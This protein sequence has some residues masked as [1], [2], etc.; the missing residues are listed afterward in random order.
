MPSAESPA[1]SPDGVRIAFTSIENTDGIEGLPDE[2][3][4][5]ILDLA[6]MTVSEVIR[7]TFPTLMSVPRW[8]PDGTKLR[9]QR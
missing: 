3:A 1:W 7:T 4:I 2:T 8:S 9:P 6:T 5:Q